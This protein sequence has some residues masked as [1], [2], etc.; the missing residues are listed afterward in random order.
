MIAAGLRVFFYL[1]DHERTLD[2]PTH[3][4]AAG[5]TVTR[6][7]EALQA[8]EDRKTKLEAE[9]AAIGP[10]QRVQPIEA[11]RVR[12]ELTALAGSW[13]RVLT[14]DPENARPIVTSLLVGRVTI[15][16]TDIPKV[17]ELRRQGTPTGLFSRFFPLG[18]ASPPGMDR[19]WKV[20]GDT[21]AA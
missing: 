10:Q 8:L 6:L 21:R 7:L 4:I 11:A 2:S 5:R 17:W 20:R 1:E 15:S 18:M 3:K 13:R 9:R 14:E 16:P 12:R 19:R